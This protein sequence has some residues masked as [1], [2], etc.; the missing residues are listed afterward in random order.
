MLPIE[1]STDM[2]SLR[3]KVDRMV[4]SCVMEI[5]HQGEILIILAGYDEPMKDLFRL[6]P[7]MLR[8]FYR[9]PFEA[10]SKEHAPALFEKKLEEEG[11]GEYLK[12]FR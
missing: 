2:C 6:N 3:P 9:I 5:D 11:Y 12:L 10:L 4:L 7:G 1:L 8:R